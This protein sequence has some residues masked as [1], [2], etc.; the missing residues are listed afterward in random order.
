MVKPELTPTNGTSITKRGTQDAVESRY[1]K[2]ESE[3]VD[4]PKSLYT[5]VYRVLDD[6]NS[7]KGGKYFQIAYLHSLESLNLKQPLSVSIEFD[8]IYYIAK[9][10][11]FPIYAIGDDVDEA[12]L[13][14]K[15]ELEELYYELQ[16]DDDFSDE[17]LRYKKL[18]KDL[19][20]Y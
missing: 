3:E 10:I 9:S 14:L 12:I 15:I 17:W 11:D 8:D 1:K 16:E 7:A 5:G 19:V 4:I 2:F 20:A 13:N 18:F 6:S